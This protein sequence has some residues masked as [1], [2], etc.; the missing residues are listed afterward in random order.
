MA[1]VPAA[2]PRAKPALPLIPAVDTDWVYFTGGTLGATTAAAYS[3]A[4]L[5][6][7]SE[8]IQMISTISSDEAVHLLIQDHCMRMSE[9]MGRRER[10]AIVG[11]A[12]GETIAATVQRAQNLNSELVN[13]AYPYFTHYDPI[14]TT[15]GIIDCSPAMYACKLLGQE[16]AVAIN[17]PLTNKQVDVLSWGVTLTPSD[18]GKLIQ[19]GVTCGAKTDD[20]DFITVRAVTTFQGNMLQENE[21]SMMREA[22][23][24]ARDL[25][26]SFKKDIGRP[27]SVV[28]VGTIEAILKTKATEWYNLG[29]IVSDGTHDLVWGIVLTDNGDNIVI[30]YHTNLTAPRNFIFATANLHVVTSLSV[31]L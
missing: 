20:G 25:R 15:N 24:M 18:Q 16:I 5:V 13:L 3:A 27:S 4:L 12:T 10:T 23:Y 7:E 9:T 19:A 8:N 29:L 22:L 30:E 28:S 11:G 31:T 14:D 21:R 26:A 6:L 2:R 1:R 17:E